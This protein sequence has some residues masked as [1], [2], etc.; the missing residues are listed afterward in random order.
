MLKWPKWRQDL[1][2]Y[3]NIKNTFIIQGNVHD[4]QPWISDDGQ[5]CSAKRLTV[6][7][8]DF[9]KEKGYEIVSVYNKVDGFFNSRSFNRA[10]TAI[11]E[12]VGA[13][14]RYIDENQPWFLAK[15][16]EKKDRLGSVLYTAMDG[17]RA[18]SY[19]IYIKR[20]NPVFTGKNIVKRKGVK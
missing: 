2:A 13:L 5:R 17:L 10:L 3:H 18:V 8:Y 6:Y 1:E 9:L 14:N 20:C 4:L 15:D 7:L 12:Y 19:F 16:P 11:W